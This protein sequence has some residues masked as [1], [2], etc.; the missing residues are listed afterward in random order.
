L[1]EL[2]K[3][4]SNKGLV[5]LA[6]PCNDFGQQEPESI[7]NIQQSCITRFNLSFNLM[8]KIHVKGNR[9]APIYNWLTSKALNGVWNTKVLWN[10][11]KYL[12]N[13]NGELINVF[14]PWVNPLDK[15][16]IHGIEKRN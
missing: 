15:K 11:Q 5:I 7:N 2:H 3:N 10:F 9:V 8:N 13:E 6:F 14:A 1:E 4:Y 16:I 12:I